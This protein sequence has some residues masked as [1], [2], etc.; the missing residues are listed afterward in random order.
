MIVEATCV[1]VNANGRFRRKWGAGT[2][3]DSDSA[4]ALARVAT[5]LGYLTLTGDASRLCEAG[6]ALHRGRASRETGQGVRGSSETT[7]AHTSRR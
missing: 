3:I 1:R 2:P 4:T 6:V 7:V 5:K